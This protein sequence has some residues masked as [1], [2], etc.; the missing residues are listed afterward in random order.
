MK[1]AFTEQYG[2][3]KVAKIRQEGSQRVCSGVLVRV[4]VLVH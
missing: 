1:E 4:L 2:T 3:N